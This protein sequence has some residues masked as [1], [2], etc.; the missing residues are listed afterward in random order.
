[1]SLK[2]I[3]APSLLSCDFSKLGEESQRII[4]DG[5]DWLHCDVMD[6]HFV[7]NITIGP[8]IIKALR[9]YVGPEAFLDCHLMVS[10]PWK[11]VSEFH[12]AGASQ[13]TLHIET[14]GMFF[15]LL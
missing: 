5:A 14:L 9:S 7:D 2:A 12:K 3:I 6:G 15:M 4:S 11:W 10:E 8:L 13:L 1:M